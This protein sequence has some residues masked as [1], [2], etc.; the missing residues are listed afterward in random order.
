MG[1][2]RLLSNTE[3]EAVQTCRAR[4]DFRYGGRLAGS[5]LKPKSVP[6]ILNEGRAWGALVAAWHGAGG[7]QKGLWEANA[8]M[9]YSLTQDFQETVA[10]G[11]RF[12]RE[13]YVATAAKLALCFQDYITRTP[14][15]T[16]LHRMEDEIIAR[17]DNKSSFLA[18]ID[19]WWIDNDGRPW[20][21]EFKWRPGGLTPT[22]LLELLPQFPRYAWA[23]REAV[24]IDPV[25]I[26]VDER[27]GRFP[28]GPK[29]LKSGDVSTDKAQF[30]TGD[31][32]MQACAEHG[33]DPVPALR[34]HYDERIWQQQIRIV[35]RPS[36]LD[37]TGTDIRELAQVVYG[38]DLGQLRPMRSASKMTCNRCDF[39]DICKNPTGPHDQFIPGVPKRL[40][41]RV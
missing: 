1:S 26:I 38:L 14:P 21:V 16:G 34:K 10:Q 39:R 25:G 4:W 9:H 18:K 22:W 8:A 35:F 41:A 29:I 6:L 15:L 37:E 33:T 40:K 32:Y 13:D 31:L 7:G 24:G 5:T 20:L 36:E 17:V 12:A 3:L 27:L 28:V 11:G 23:L 19:G 30:T 2:R